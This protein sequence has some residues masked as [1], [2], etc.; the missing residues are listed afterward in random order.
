[1]YGIISQWNGDLI[2]D[3]VTYQRSVRTYLTPVNQ[4]ISDRVVNEFPQFG[5]E[6]RHMCPLTSAIP[7]IHLY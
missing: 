3:D 2:E 4:I 5:E 6:S 7:R 1:M